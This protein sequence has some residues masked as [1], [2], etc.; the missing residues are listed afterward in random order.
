MCVTSSTTRSLFCRQTPRL[1]ARRPPTDEP[2]S[3]PGRRRPLSVA[4]RI[5]NWQSLVISR[6]WSHGSSPPFLAVGLMVGERLR[7]G[8]TRRRDRFPRAPA[9]KGASR[10]GFGPSSAGRDF[11]VGRGYGPIPSR[12]PYAPLSMTMHSRRSKRNCVDMLRNNG[13]TS[14]DVVSGLAWAADRGTAVG[15]GKREEMGGR[16]QV[17]NRMLRVAVA[18]A[19]IGFVAACEAETPTPTVLNDVAPDVALPS[20]DIAKQAPAA[21]REARQIV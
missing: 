7:W 17:Q 13:D 16:T 15:E 8:I 9:G 6:R 18:I 2:R 4:A 11:A 19:A 1:P 3:A 10:L 5:S 14:I 21:K 20:P 12:C